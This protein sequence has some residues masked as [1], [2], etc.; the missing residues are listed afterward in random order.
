MMSSSAASGPFEDACTGPA[1][2]SR[3]RAFPREFVWGVATAAYQIEGSA[4]VDGR[5]ASIWDTFVKLPGRVR[6]GSTGDIA[7]DHY[8][9]WRED[10]D[11]VSWMGLTAYRF[12]ISWSRWQPDGAGALNP[13]GV[14]FYDRMVD[15]LLDRG[16]QPWATLYH[17]DL[18]QALQDA[19]GW[20]QRDVAHRFAEY[21][22][23]VADWLGDRLSTIITV[24]EPWC[25]AF[26]GHSSG[27]HAP[28][29]QDDEAA[30]RAAHHLLLGHGEAIAALRAR[31]GP[32]RLG[33]VLNNHPVRRLAERPDDL[34]AVRRI[35]GLTNRFFLDP[36]LRG[37]YPVDVIADVASIT[38]FHHVEDGDL[39]LVSAGLDLLGVSY[40]C[41][42]V[43]T[44]PG[45]PEA[46]AVTAGA[47]R[48]GSSHDGWLPR[49][50]WVGSREAAFALPDPSLPAM[51]GDPSPSGLSEVLDRL[52]TDYSCPPIYITENGAAVE[53][54]MVDGRVADTERAAY[55][56]DHLAACLETL[57]DGVDVRGYFVRSLL[58]DFEWS[59]GYT[60]RFGITHVDFHTLR[61][62]PK[63]SAHHLRRIVRGNALPVDTP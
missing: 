10:L 11:L 40:H 26:L 8:R 55:L 44:A 42:Y 25:S 56:V 3:P 41:P 19:G 31:G 22:G 53:D 13:R 15:G 52:A 62:T 46:M 18:P 2:P 36:L 49:S 60:R 54:V 58:D 5:G 34:E 59:W 9:R 33:I 1:R 57:E 37:S 24:N 28:G 51:G 20:P 21:A 38:D 35:D 39:E 43:V 16:I 6:D 32:A 29:V 27:V 47:R 63:A 50:P 7:C 30:L 61:R 4:D 14:A 45:T 12:S 23:S 48:A 17:W